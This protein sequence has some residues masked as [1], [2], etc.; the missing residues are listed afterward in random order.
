MQALILAA[1]VGNRI[2]G[3]AAG[4]PKSYLPLCGET[5]LTRNLRL[6]RECGVKEC[7]IVTGHQRE[8]FAA[9]FPDSDI[10]QV[11]NPFYKTTN[12]LVSVWCGLPWITGEFI[13]LHADTVFDPRILHRLISAPSQPALLAA[14]RKV[15]AEEEMKYKAGSDGCVFEINKTMPP[16]E[17]HGEFL[18]LARFSPAALPVIRSGVERVLARGEFGSFF[19]AALQEM[20]DA[21]ELSPAVVDAGDLPWREIDFP[22]DY[23]AAKSLFA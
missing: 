18:G 13:Y 15:C 1:G 11:F 4:M 8:R 10:R 21:R 5:L 2:A 16:G 9:D 19:E 14:D 6:L 12:V 20:I 23:E 3:A 7:V 17:A 22:E